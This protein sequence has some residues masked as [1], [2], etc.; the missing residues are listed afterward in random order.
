MMKKIYWTD[1][2]I[3]E[4]S[5]VEFLES[6]NYSKY[7][8][9]IS[10]TVFNALGLE[11]IL[12]NK[13]LSSKDYK[14]LLEVE[15]ETEKGLVE[16]GVKPTQDYQPD[17]I[18]AI[19]GGSVIDAAKQLWLFYELPHL[20]WDDAKNF[21]SMEDFPGKCDLIAV[22]TTSGTGS[23]MT[24]CAMYVDDNNE[25]KMF[26][27]NKIIPTMSI[28]DASLIMTLPDRPF[29]YSTVDAFTHAL[30]AA[31]NEG[32]DAVTQF[33]GIQSVVTIANNIQKAKAKDKDAREKLMVA[34]SF[35]GVAIN[36]GN[37]GMSHTL[38]Y[39]GEDFHLPHGLITGMITPYWIYYSDPDETYEVILKQLNQTLEGP[40]NIQ[41]SKF[42]V[43]M[44]KS[45]GLPICLVD[46]N[47]SESEYFGHIAK[48][49]EKYY[50]GDSMFSL[51]K[52]NPE[53]RALID[54]YENLYS[55]KLFKK[56]G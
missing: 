5:L 15:V 36:N 24:G 27:D 8:F 35:A 3:G 20:T 44:Y 26:L 7:G 46:M 9:V 31:T 11:E 52:F 1:L 39:P 50:E 18:I 40:S 38:N 34:A 47:V 30:E 32:V 49:V 41:L 48:Y 43:E 17:V 37:V 29:L 14:V 55:G 28:L 45:V 19:G 51:S 56:E 23:E 33:L 4:N 21:Y 42:I 10:R 13:V 22:P 2:V 25:K 6:S 53:A 16:T 54:L 12:F